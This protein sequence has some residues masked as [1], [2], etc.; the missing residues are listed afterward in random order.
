MPA[1]SAS[2]GDTTT[3]TL[4]TLFRDSMT[5]GSYGGLS[6]WLTTTAAD[7]RA[8]NRPIH[9]LL[10][11]SGAECGLRVGCSVLA[12]R[13]AATTVVPAVRSL[14]E[15]ESGLR[16]SLMLSQRRCQTLRRYQRCTGRRCF[17]ES[18]CLHLLS[19]C[20]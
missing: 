19:T 5:A 16:V 13:S 20:Y 4:D 1:S 7:A 12:Y 15:R 6:G 17:L 9:T 3:V 11:V 2:R 8:L 18:Q 14:E 10:L